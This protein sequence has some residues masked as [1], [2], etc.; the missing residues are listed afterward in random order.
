MLAADQAAWAA[1]RTP[2]PGQGDLVGHVSPGSAPQTG[3]LKLERWKSDGPEVVGL[4]VELEKLG[5]SRSCSH[6]SRSEQKDPWAQSD[7][8]RRNSLPRAHKHHSFLEKPLLGLHE[9]KHDS[10]WECKG[11]L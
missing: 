3:L 9:I 1:T 4:P 5:T 10:L 11:F 8:S 7:S 6:S 2:R